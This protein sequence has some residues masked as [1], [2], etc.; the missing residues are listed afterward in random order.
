MMDVLMR[1]E[2]IEL[3]IEGRNN[4]WAGIRGILDEKET[5]K[6]ES[7]LPPAEEAESLEAGAGQET[8][9]A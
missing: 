5:L 4:R 8:A 2:N 7:A 3:A 9:G 1:V 6:Q